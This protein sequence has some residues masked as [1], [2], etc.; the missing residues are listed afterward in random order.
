MVPTLSCG[1]KRTSASWGGTT[2]TPLSLRLCAR[3]CRIAP[4]G[5]ASYPRV[6]SPFYRYGR[7]REDAAPLLVLLQVCEV[8]LTVSSAGRCAALGFLQLHRVVHH[9]RARAQ[10]RP[11]VLVGVRCR[12]ERSARV[13]TG[14]AFWLGTIAQPSTLVAVAV[15]SSL[16]FTPP[17]SPSV[18]TSLLAGCPCSR[19][20]RVAYQACWHPYPASCRRLRTS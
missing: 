13:A 7:S 14:C 12:A 5:S 2:T 19:A 1:G 6:L 15:P 8:L 18:V 3:R 20:A 9:S 17:P 10:T 4:R 11:A 16:H